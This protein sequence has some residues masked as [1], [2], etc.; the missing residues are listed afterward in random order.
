MTLATTWSAARNPKYSNSA[1][2]LIDVEVNFD[3]VPDETWSPCTVVASGDQPHIHDLYARCVAGD[4][5]TVA[6]WVQP[7]DLTG[8][9]VL[10]ELRRQRDEKLAETDHWAYQDTPA[11]TAAQTTYR[12]DLRDMPADNPN[13]ALRFVEDEGWTQWVNVTWPVKP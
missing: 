9:D 1:H 4:Y 5:G 11:M 10:N 7:A 2:T 8:S 12:Q 13:A 3:D 6:D